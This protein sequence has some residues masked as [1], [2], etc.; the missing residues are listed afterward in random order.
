MDKWLEAIN[1][2]M[3]L[4][5]LVFATYRASKTTDTVILKAILTLKEELNVA[6][7]KQH[8]YVF[9]NMRKRI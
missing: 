6:Y 1:G 4:G 9:L 8:S 5:V 7:A 3:F 2:N